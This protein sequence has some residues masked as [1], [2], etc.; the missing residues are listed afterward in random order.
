MANRL[1]IKRVIAKT[2]FNAYYTKGREVKV[3]IN[4][5]FSGK[6]CMYP[7]DDNSTT[8]EG[9]YMVFDTLKDI[10]KYFTIN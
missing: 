5:L 1:G 7:H 9:M 2:N 4:N 6:I 10:E 8:T 3:R